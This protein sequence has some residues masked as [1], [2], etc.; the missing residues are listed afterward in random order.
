MKLNSVGFAH[1]KPQT[2]LPLRAVALDWAALAAPVGQRHPEGLVSTC[3]G[4]REMCSFLA[5]WFVQLYTSN[6][7]AGEAAVFDVILGADILYD[8]R[9]LQSLVLALHRYLAPGGHFYCVDPGRL[10]NCA[11]RKSF[12][13]LLLEAHP[14][15]E[16][17]EHTMETYTRMAEMLCTTPDAMH[18]SQST[19]QQIHIHLH[20]HRRR[21][22]AAALGLPDTALGQTVSVQQLIAADAPYTLLAVSRPCSAKKKHIVVLQCIQTKLS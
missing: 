22:L 1:W 5:C 9:S 18:T 2:Q 19:K 15:W 17:E 10:D 8:R 3:R 11:V 4:S 14:E 16:Y 21:G 13:S 20:E 7:P 6:A 12:V